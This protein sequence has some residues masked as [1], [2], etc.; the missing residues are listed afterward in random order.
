MKLERKP[1]DF[2]ILYQTRLWSVGMSYLRKPASGP[3]KSISK[4]LLK[5]PTLFDLTNDGNDHTEEV[6]PLE[7]SIEE[8]MEP[9]HNEPYLF[10]EEEFQRRL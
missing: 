4:Y 5:T 9:H 7:E 1:I 3:N 2:M 8:P 6:M 10:I